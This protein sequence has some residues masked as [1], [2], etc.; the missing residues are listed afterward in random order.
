MSGNGLTKAEQ[1]YLQSLQEFP[2][3]VKSRLLGW[4]L[5]LL[6]GIG[7]FA[8]GLYSDQ[9]FLLVLGFLTLLY[10]TLWRMYGQLRGFRML[11]NILASRST[12]NDK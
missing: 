9:R 2:K 1:A 6:P 7:L 10:F 5:E 8:Y 11:G 12:N 3:S 4:A